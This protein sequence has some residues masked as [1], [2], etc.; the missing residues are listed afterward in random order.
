MMSE[1][2]FALLFYPI[3]KRVQEKEEISTRKIENALI[4]LLALSALF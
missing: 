4:T 1:I 3:G 2:L